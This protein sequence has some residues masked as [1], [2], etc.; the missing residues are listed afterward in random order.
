[1]PIAGKRSKVLFLPVIRGNYPASLTVEVKSRVRE[2]AEELGIDGIFPA[3]DLYTQGLIRSDEDVRGY[4]EA[5][6]GDLSDIKAL[7]AFSGD[8]MRERAI[9]DTVRLL[10]PDV[11]VF[12]IVNNDDPTAMESGKVGDSL[13][14][15]L[16]VHH[17][18]RMLGRRVVRSCRIDVHDHDFLRAFLAQYMLIIDGVECLRNMRIAMLGVNPEAFATTFANQMKLF[19][20][21]FSLHPYELITL[22]GDTVL[23]REVADGETTYEGPF[24]KVQLWR[25]IGRDDGRVAE[26][27]AGLAEIMDGLPEDDKVDVIARSF[28]WMQDTF[29]QDRIDAGAIHCWSEFSRFFGV[30]PCTAAMLSNLRLEKPVVCEQDVCHAIMAKL[31]WEMT[32]EPGVILDIN[33]NGW[34]PRVFNVFHCSQTPPNWL[35]GPGKVG[36]WGS[37]EGRMAP[38][39]FT[40]VSAA[41]TSEEFVAVVFQGQML[42][43]PA[44]DRG[45]SGWAFVPNLQEVLKV[46]EQA[47]IHHF[48]AMKGHLGDEV[49]DVLKFKGLVVADMSCDVDD[50]ED[51]E[52]ELPAPD[53]E[54]ASG[55]SV[56]SY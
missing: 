6:R 22:W 33:N 10:P 42:R 40:A 13:C 28:L 7:V 26:V 31:A 53:D 2:A 54:D 16:S 3:D 41:T 32:G 34:D 23:A 15:S 55:R 38:E 44:G 19:E 29:A 8:F 56:F 24:G 5:W 37:I 4:W 51:I 49:A 14:G 21:G 52:A 27:K 50:L 11:P 43:R 46:I 25:P 45:S 17:N 30:A 47:G 1:M 20:L 36:G 12:L 35:A 48:V 39:P 9:Q 18:L